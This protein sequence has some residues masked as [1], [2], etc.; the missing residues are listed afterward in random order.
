MISEKRIEVHTHLRL[1][2]EETEW[3]KGLL[4]NP[5]TNAED[6]QTTMMRERFFNALTKE[7]K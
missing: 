2:D 3:L 5:L 7:T 4:Q 1:N 6:P